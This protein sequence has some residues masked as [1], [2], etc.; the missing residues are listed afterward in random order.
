MGLNVRTLLPKL[1]Q[2]ECGISQAI[3]YDS[4]GVWPAFQRENTSCSSVKSTSPQN[5]APTFLIFS[6][7]EPQVPS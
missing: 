7:I 3:L 5:P 4:L 1:S 2:I 6:K